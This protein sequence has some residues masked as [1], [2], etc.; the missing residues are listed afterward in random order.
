M[1]RDVYHERQWKVSTAFRICHE[2]KS[3]VERKALCNP[4]HHSGKVA[5]SVEIFWLSV[6]SIV[7]PDALPE[8]VSNMTLMSLPTKEELNR[9]EEEEDVDKNCIKMKS[10]S[11]YS[12]DM[13]PCEL[14]SHAMSMV[15]MLCQQGK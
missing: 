3:F 9:Y 4:I 1:A 14:L 13:Q 15:S 2:A 11:N 8:G 5:A 7:C 12:V 6:A 10:S